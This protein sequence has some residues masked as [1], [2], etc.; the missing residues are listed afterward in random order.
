[1]ANEK[2]YAEGVFVEVKETSFGE[3]IKL[4]INPKFIEFYNQNKNEAGYLNIDLLNSQ[5]GGKYAVLN[6]Y[7]PKSQDSES[8]DSGLPF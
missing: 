7:V 4:A 1:M 2:V 8:E 5:K 6:T 3:I